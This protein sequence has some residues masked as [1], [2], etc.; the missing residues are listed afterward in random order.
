MQVIHVRLEQHFDALSETRQAVQP[1]APVFALEHGLSEAE[2]VASAYRGPAA[3][4]QHRI[5][6]RA[7]I[8]LVVYA[9]EIGYSYSGDEYWQTFEASTPGWALL[10]SAI[11]SERGSRTSDASSTA[12]SQR[13]L[14]PASS[15]S[16][17]GRSRTR[18]C[19]PTSSGNSRSCC[20]NIAERSRRI[21]WPRRT[22]SGGISEQEHG[23]AP[24]GSRSLPRTPTSSAS[25][26][27]RSCR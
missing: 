23:T 4:K 3:V 22:N 12:P 1:H 17:A 26:R 25:L 18:C 13:A 9:S 24:R 19:P 20:S 21:S 6:R 8:P 16:S 10:D 7:W 5:D 14:G 15:P 2:L 11:T 27:R